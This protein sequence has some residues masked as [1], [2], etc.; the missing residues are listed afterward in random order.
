MEYDIASWDKEQQV[1]QVVAKLGRTVQDRQGYLRQFLYG[2]DDVR[3]VS[4]KGSQWKILEEILSQ[5]VTRRLKTKTAG[6][7]YR[8]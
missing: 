4:S 5:R 2:G 1:R 6:I 3:S 8:P 7:E